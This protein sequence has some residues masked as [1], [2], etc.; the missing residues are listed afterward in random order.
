MCT[1]SFSLTQKPVPPPPATT[2]NPQ[3]RRIPHLRTR[4]P[5][6]DS[7]PRT[8]APNPSA[9]AGNPD[10]PIPTPTPPRLRRPQGGKK[11]YKAF[12]AALRTKGDGGQEECLSYKCADLNKIVPESMGV[13]KAILESVVFVHQVRGPS[14][15]VPSRPV[16]SRPVPSRPV[17][18]RPAPSHPVPPRPIQVWTSF[19]RFEADGE[20]ADAAA[21][22]YREGEDYFR[23]ISGKEERAMLLESWQQMEEATG[24][25]ARVEEVKKRMPTRIKKKRPL[26]ADDGTPMGWEEYYDYIFPEEQAKAP[27]LKI[28]EMA[29][30]WKKQKTGGEDD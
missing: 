2:P 16:P 3:P 6:N 20:G 22:V 24:D 25:E 10:A 27:S 18:S 7:H 12:E 8:A 5:P 29:Q 23:D 9:T 1:R 15:P 17:P 30:K 11:D 28:L 14:R 21:A 19:A 4:H 13:S 26:E